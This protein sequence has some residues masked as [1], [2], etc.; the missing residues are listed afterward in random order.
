MS[1]KADDFHSELD[2]LLKAGSEHGF[3]AVDLTAGALHRRIGDYP[4]AD[5][6]MPVCCDVMRQAMRETDTVV[7]EPKK[8]AGASLMIRYSLPR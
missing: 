4:G 2:R 5:H 3:S 1:P 7:E 8:G 6:R